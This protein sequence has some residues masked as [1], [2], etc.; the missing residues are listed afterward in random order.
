M[1]PPRIQQR[2]TPTGADWLCLHPAFA[3]LSAVLPFF[4]ILK[5]DQRLIEKQSSFQSS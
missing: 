2:R 1:D 5:N 4:K 3:G